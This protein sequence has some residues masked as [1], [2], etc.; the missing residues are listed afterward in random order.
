M[1]INIAEKSVLDRVLKRKRMA[2]HDGEEVDLTGTIKSVLGWANEFVPS[3]SGSILLD[4]PVLDKRK[5]KPGRLYFVACFGEGSAPI[6]GTAI[7]AAVGIVGKTYRRGTPYISERVKDDSFF[8]D[9]IDK[10]TNFSTKSIVCAPIRIRGVT[11]GVIEL[12]NRLDGT[13]YAPRDL[14][15]LEIFAGYT[16]TLIQ[17]S[18]DAKRFEELSIIDNL[19]G[20]HNDRFLFY[21]M[22]KAV[23]PSLRENK[24][25]SFVYFDLDR[26]KEVNDT[27]GHLAGSELLRELGSIIKDIIEGTKFVAVRYGGDE[28][29]IVLPGVDL[30]AA[31]GFAEDLRKTIEGHVFLAHKVPG[32]GRPLNIKGLITAS[33]GVAAL[34]LE[35]AT[36]DEVRGAQETLLKQA[37]K[38]MYESK[39]KGKN[40]VTSVAVKPY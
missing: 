18:L 37:D 16:S 5:K 33:F 23:V 19:T 30:E 8:Y 38:V 4:D 11:I 10:K 36:L 17:N 9:G 7:P 35:T 32:Y 34:G 24:N 26:F 28:F 6:T 27:H 25:L 39:D 21:N 3:E 13:N 40:T 15:L 29:A 22:A 20:L 2:G 14:T 12:I 31:E 1:H